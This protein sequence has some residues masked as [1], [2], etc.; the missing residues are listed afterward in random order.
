[1]AANIGGTSCDYVRG[2]VTPLRE[3]VETWVVPG[4][5]SVGAMLL[6]QNEGQAAVVAT[7][8]NTVGAC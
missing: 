3:R 8:L 4:L 1:M 6:G 5:D 7:K 2:D